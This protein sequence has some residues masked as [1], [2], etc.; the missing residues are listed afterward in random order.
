MLSVGTLGA[1]ARDDL[2]ELYLISNNHVI[3]HP[4]T[5]ATSDPIVQVRTLDLTEIEM[6]LMSDTP[7]VANTLKIA[8]L[9]DFVP[10]QFPTPQ[11]VPL[12]R[13][14]TAIAR[15]ISNG[16]DTDGIHCLAFA[17]AIMGVADP[18]DV[19]NDGHPNVPTRVYK[20]GR[21]TGLTEGE[22][23]MI[24][25]IVPIPYPQGVAYFTDQIIVHP[26]DD[27]AGP[28]SDQGDSG[29]IVLDER[30]QVL[31]LLYAGSPRRT[32]I[33]PIEFVLEDLSNQI[34]RPLTLVTL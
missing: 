10:I 18:I 12:N 24:G 31:G 17:G 34:N 14:D 23:D 3:A 15:L 13:S 16:R 20:M 2:N 30:H 27:N 5:G 26:T 8:E 21:T 9:T 1:F 19:D 7:A 29:S 28:F 4:N 25:A 6:S 33:N 22:V 32:F 11:N